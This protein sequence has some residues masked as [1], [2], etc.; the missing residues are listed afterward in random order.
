VTEQRFERSMALVLT[1]GVVIS[2]AFVGVGFAGSFVV[3]WTGS[4]LG[5]PSPST[6]T[7][8]FSALLARVAILQ[9]LALVQTGLV[10]LIAT[11]VVRVGATTL[12]FW[13]QHDTLYVAVSLLVLVLLALSLGLLR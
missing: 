7:T 11:P 13:R 3:G 8:D 12:G 2:A 5:A 9:P 4:L 10:V 6:Q 1:A